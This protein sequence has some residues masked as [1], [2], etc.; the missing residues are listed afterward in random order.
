MAGHRQFPKVTIKPEDAKKL[1]EMLVKIN[2]QRSK[3][4]KPALSLTE[5]VDEMI[6]KYAENT[7]LPTFSKKFME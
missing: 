2:E 5:L 6:K 4:N 7:P 3:D 1:H